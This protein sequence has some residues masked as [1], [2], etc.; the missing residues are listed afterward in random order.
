MSKVKKK[1]EALLKRVRK[2][3]EKIKK[4]RTASAKKA[5]KKK[6]AKPSAKKKAGSKKKSGTTKKRSSK[7]N[8]RGNGSNAG[9]ISANQTAPNGDVI[10]TS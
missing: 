3:N 6:R 4:L 2:L 5:K 1:I 10:R 9:L 8:L 7:P